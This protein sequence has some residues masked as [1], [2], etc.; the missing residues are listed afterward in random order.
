M[1]ENSKTEIICEEIKFP[2]VVYEGPDSKLLE[3]ISKL[4]AGTFRIVVFTIV[5]LIMGWFS[6]LYYTDSFIVTKVILAVPYKISEAIYVSVIGTR[7]IAI[8]ML[9]SP[10]G[11]TIF[12]S[13]SIIATFLAER[14]TP[15][16]IGGALYGCLGYFT[17]D[18]RVFTLQR[19]VKFVCVHAVILIVFIGLVY[20]V[21]AK[22]VY[23]N[24][25]LKDVQYF[26]LESEK[27]SET[28]Y[29]KRADVLRESF[30]RDLQRDESI[31]QDMADELPI[32]IIFAN[33]TRYMRAAVN[34]RKHYLVTEDGSTYRVS[35]EFC[36]YV[37][38]YYDTG[39]LM[40]TQNII[41]DEEE[42]SDERN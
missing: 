18:K 15:M 1:T 2:E 14:M 23:D 41:V 7:N 28:V 8:Q 24:N 39:S 36:G 29:D 26:F 42:M 30:E 32:Q 11:E 38:E 4:K 33:N 9:G 6:Y 20:G 31:Q 5:G 22:A 34:V 13:N 17:G 3:L 16:L 21:N 27:C 10:M 35:E 12:F 19:F 37:K 40:G 25:H